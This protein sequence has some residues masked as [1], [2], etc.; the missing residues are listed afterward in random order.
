MADSYA[1]KVRTKEGRILDGKM[2][3]DGESA[4]ANK[5]RSQGF[6]PIQIAKDAKVSIKM[7]L[8]ILPQRV[9]LR[10]LAVAPAGPEHPGRADGKP[11][12]RGGRE[13]PS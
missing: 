6:I 11:E 1:Y 12:A 8:H 3:A 9:T 2:E 4:V 5:L 7:E 13:E 10:D